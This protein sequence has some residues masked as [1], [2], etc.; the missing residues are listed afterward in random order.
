M[1]NLMQLTAG[2]LKHEKKRKCLF[3]KDRKQNKKAK[4]LRNCQKSQL[5]P[6]TYY[7]TAKIN[8]KNYDF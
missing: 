6:R 5:S 7:N 1:I 8:K 3:Y 4:T 2:S